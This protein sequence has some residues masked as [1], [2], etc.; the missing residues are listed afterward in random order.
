MARLGLTILSFNVQTINDKDG[1]IDDLGID[2]RSQIQKEAS[3][4]KANAERDVAVQKANADNEANKAKVAADMEIAKRDNE[5]EIRKSELKILEDTKKAEADMAY[6]IQKETSRKTEEIRKQE[7][8]I[9]QREKE[10]ELQA[11]EAEVAVQKLAAEVEKPAEAEKNAAIFKADADLYTRQKEAEAKLYEEMKAAEAIEAKGHAEAQAIRLKGEAEADAMDKKADA[12]KKYGQAAI[13]EMIV[14]VL[15]DLAKAVAEPIS[16]IDEVKI[17][18]GD[19]NGISD[20]AGN[21]PVMLAKVMESVKEATG[22]DI[23]EI[24]KAETYGAKVNRN[25]TINGAVPVAEEENGK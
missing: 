12:M 16:S 11:K 21:V 23:Q 22:I 20:M 5:L 18:G 13:L 8:N 15:P 17:I 7:V 1:L 9:A 6:S 4:A 3:I 14:G 10:I 2:N 24:A 25:V 19:S